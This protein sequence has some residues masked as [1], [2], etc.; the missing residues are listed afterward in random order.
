SIRHHLLEDDHF[1]EINKGGAT[2]SCNSF[3]SFN[4]HLLRKN[5]GDILYQV[6]KYSAGQYC[7]APDTLEEDKVYQSGNNIVL[8]WAKGEEV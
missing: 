3:S 7:L 6:D 5:W 8:H 2:L 4:N 1:P